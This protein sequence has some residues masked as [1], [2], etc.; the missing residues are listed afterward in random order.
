MFGW[1]KRRLLARRARKALASVN[2]YDGMRAKH[3]ELRAEAAAHRSTPP[4]YSPSPS[5]PLHNGDPMGINHAL[6]LSAL[7]DDG[8][9][10]SVDCSSSFSSSDSSSSSSSYDSSS[11]CSSSS[12]SGWD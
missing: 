6:A 3:A 12:S 8:H 9:R 7:R 2:S 4:A 1:I 11:S 10:S 5:Y